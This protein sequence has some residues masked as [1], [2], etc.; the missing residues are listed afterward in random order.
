M[1][2]TNAA[3]FHHIEIHTIQPDYILQLFTKTYG[4]Q[5]IASRR[6]EYYQ[7][8]FLRSGECRLIISSVLSEFDFD[9]TTV[10]PNECQD[11]DILLSILRRSTTRELIIKRD[12]VFNVALQVKSIDRILENNPGL[13]VSA[14]TIYL[15]FV[16]VFF[17]TSLLSW[18][19][20]QLFALD[21]LASDVTT[22]GCRCIWFHQVCLYQ[23]MRWEC[24]TY[25]DRYIQIHR[26]QFTGFHRCFWFSR[27][28]IY[29]AAYRSCSLC[30]GTKSSDI[31]DGLV[32]KS[33]W[34]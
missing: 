20:K 16:P 14:R 21:F 18:E 9:L 4:F 10:L 31:D 29:C 7:Q 23:I 26:S 12:T 2:T 17:V 25:I 22:F 8:W 24:C 5:I 1:R 13:K 28:V 34:F 27:R 11:Y 19:D 3:S 15:A 33:F 30:S 32:W 6:T